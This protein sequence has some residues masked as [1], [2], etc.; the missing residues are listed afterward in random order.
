MLLAA[1]Y[2]VDIAGAVTQL[3]N[4]AFQALFSSGKLGVVAVG[5]TDPGLSIDFSPGGTSI[6]VIPSDFTSA[7]QRAA[8]KL[9]LA[10]SISDAKG[11]MAGSL[12]IDQLSL[13]A[14]GDPVPGHVK[15]VGELGAAPIVG[16][17]PGALVTF[18]SGSLEAT[19]GSTPVVSFSGSLTLPNRPVAT[20]TV[21]V[22][23]TSTVTGASSLEGRYV[24]GGI[25]VTITGSKSATGSTATF[26]DSSGVSTTVGSHAASANVTV[27][28]RQTAVI[29]K[30]TKR[31]SY[32]DGTFESLF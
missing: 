4:G 2:P 20:L 24:Q 29:D 28:G 30:D 22:T 13:D 19:L 3:A 27:G 16:G 25:T 32:S 12:L 8:A 18:L 23:E 17:Q 9:N 10:A 26:A 21:S 6:A 14:N 11:H 5:A 1:R 7:A 15:F 31:I